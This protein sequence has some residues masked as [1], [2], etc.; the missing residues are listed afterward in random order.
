MIILYRYTVNRNIHN[1]Y[2]IAT[3]MMSVCT[4]LCTTVQ[5]C[6][7][8]CCVCREVTIYGVQEAERR[9]VCP[10]VVAAWHWYGWR[11]LH[12]GWTHGW[13]DDDVRS[14]G[15]W[16]VRRAA[17]VFIPCS[18]RVSSSDGWRPSRWRLAA[19]TQPHHRSSYV[20]NLILK[21]NKRVSIGRS[22]C[23]W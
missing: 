9:R 2:I 22:I 7:G 13:T 21:C 3:I 5:P 23:I 16:A 18:S 8:V 15:R 12:A 6:A 19:N 20:T 4:C 10:T 1:I 14:S 11:C 17:A